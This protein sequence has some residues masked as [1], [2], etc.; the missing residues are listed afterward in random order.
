MLERQFRRH[1]A[2]AERRQGQTGENLLRILETRLDNVVYRLGFADSRPQ[3]RQMVT[4]GHFEL[5]GRKLDIPSAIVRPG[6]IVSVREPEVRPCWPGLLSNFALSLMA[7]RA[8]F[9]NRSVPSRRES[10]ALGPR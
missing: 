6:D 10:L 5:N 9:R 4:H 1:F 3:A 8:L 7:R 2:E